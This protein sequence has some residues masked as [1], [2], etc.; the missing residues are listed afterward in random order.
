MH[1]DAKIQHFIGSLERVRWGSNGRVVACCPAHLDRNPSLSV[2][3]GERGLL[4][5]C[6]AGCT[7]EEIVQ[8]MGLRTTNLFYD[9]DSDQQQPRCRRPIHKPWRYDWRR[10]SADLLFKAESLQ[11]RTESILSA[12]QDVD[13]HDC[14]DADLDTAL[15]A[16]S[17]AY[18]DQE[19]AEFLW[20]VSF[21]LR[22]RGLALEREA[23]K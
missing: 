14:T 18:Q 10:V 19:R 7:V 17:R 11:I 13:I 1:P 6:W 2:S 4:V 12:F 8:A 9:W 21:H 16:V 20:D 15:G 22:T 5:K 23:C 3:L